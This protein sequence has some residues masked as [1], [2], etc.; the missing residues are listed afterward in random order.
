MSNE[1]ERLLDFRKLHEGIFREI[2][3]APSAQ[4]GARESAQASVQ[5]GALLAEPQDNEPGSTVKPRD[6]SRYLARVESVAR[7]LEQTKT[8][9]REMEIAVD[10]LQQREMELESSLN[11]AA[12]RNSQLEESFAAERNRAARAQSMAA[13]AARRI[14]ELEAALAEAN[15]RADALTSAIEKAFSDIVDKPSSG[16]AAAA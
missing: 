15:A 10:H 4:D 13:E 9:A 12:Y 8:H 11:E 1:I 7:M 2:N 5:E 3:R 6:M 16:A 14:Q